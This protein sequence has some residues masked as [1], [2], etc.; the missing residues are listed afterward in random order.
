M[1]GQDGATAA[2]GRASLSKVEARRRKTQVGRVD[3][4]LDLVLVE[5]SPTYRGEVTVDFDLVGAKDGLL[6]DV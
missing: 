3:Y 2:G 4:A 6:P 1:H 5:K